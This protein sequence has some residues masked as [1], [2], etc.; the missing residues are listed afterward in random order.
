[1]A[2]TPQKREYSQAMKQEKGLSLEILSDPGNMTAR[3]Y[4]LV[5]TLPD[6]LTG[7]YRGFGIDL[8]NFNGED[9]WALPMPARLI[10]DGQG[11]VRYAAINADYTVRP[12]P[13]HT[14]EALRK[15]V[16]G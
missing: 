12:E 7:I 3:Q 10:I 13:E 11:T 15:I 14:L 8:P 4:G 5:Y 1:M 2:I 9:S 16:T 6:N